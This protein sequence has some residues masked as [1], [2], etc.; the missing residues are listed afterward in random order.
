MISKNKPR[1]CFVSDGA[2]DHTV[3]LKSEKLTD[4]VSAVFTDNNLYQKAQR[5]FTDACVYGTGFI[6]LNPNKETKKV[7]AEWVFIEEIK[8]D[9]IDSRNQQPTQ[10]H[11]VRFMSKDKL[12]A[13]YPKKA[14]EILSANSGLSGAS[15]TN[16]QADVV[17]VRESW[18]LP[19][20]KGYSDGLYVLSIEDT[21]LLKKKYDKPYFPIVAFRWYEQAYGFFGRGICQQIFRIQVRIN[22]ILNTIE[23]AQRLIAVPIIFIDA[24]SNVAEDHI[25]SNEVA[26]MV[27][28]TGMKP[29]IETPPAVQPE[30]YEHLNWLEAEAFKQT[31]VSQGNATGQKPPEVES[32]QAIREVADIASGRFEV[33]GQNWEQ[34]FIT[35]AEQIVDMSQDLFKGSDMVSINKKSSF[36]KVPFKELQLEASEYR[37]DC[38]PISGFPNSPAARM[39]MASDYLT[40]GW[41]TEEQFMEISNIPDI[42]ETTSLITASL[43]LTE[44]WLA[45]MKENGEYHEPIEVMDLGTAYKYSVLEACRARTQKVKPENIALIERFGNACLDMQK[46]LEPPPAPPMA[47]PPPGAPQ[48][49]PPG[50]PPPQA[51]PG[52]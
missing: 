51:P 15:L 45:D 19:S 14:D 46:Q 24:G 18:H 37:I 4:Y 50:Q 25:G 1:P 43:K 16:T 21:I 13:T 11:R 31:G 2:A 38:M 49:P 12:I 23:K 33:V 17:Q 40:K 35:L 28:Y 7:E 5:A 47:G 8:V 52:Q 30:L 36:I 34:F 3:A 42:K 20:K 9:E 41:I 48:G 26:H 39:Q 32:G 6:A 27:E 44:E 29:S 10:M 22:E